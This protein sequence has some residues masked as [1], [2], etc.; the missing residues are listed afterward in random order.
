MLNQKEKE[1]LY[2]NVFGAMKH[3]DVDVITEALKGVHED[4]QVWVLTARS[5]F[6]PG[7][8]PF[9]AILQSDETFLALVKQLPEARY[10]E[11]YRVLE[12]GNTPLTEALSWN[13]TGKVQALLVGI[14]DDSVFDALLNTKNLDNTSLK[15]LLGEKSSKSGNENLLEDITKAR[16]AALTG[17]CKAEANWIESA[18]DLGLLGLFGGDAVEEEETKETAQEET[19]ETVFDMSNVG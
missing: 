13:I 8:I 19:V 11:V 15:T 6:F 1:E 14:Q 16:Q 10:E 5:N 12:D 17:E 9:A 7:T 3:N 2:I 4:D 18:S